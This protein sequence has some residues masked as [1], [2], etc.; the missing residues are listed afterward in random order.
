MLYSCKRRAP[1]FHFGRIGL[2]L[3]E[4]QDLSSL[5]PNRILGTDSSSPM[6]PNIHIHALDI[7]P[8]NFYRLV[9][10]LREATQQHAP[11]RE[12]CDAPPATPS[13]TRPP[14]AEQYA[15]ITKFLRSGSRHR[16]RLW[17]YRAYHEATTDI[18]RRFATPQYRYYL[19]R[20]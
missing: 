1:D 18:R 12:V 5:V 13:I 16:P 20:M 7:F 15:N 19:F 8:R 11:T 2:N 17:A 4:T 14:P 3:K 10:P 9:Q 6:I